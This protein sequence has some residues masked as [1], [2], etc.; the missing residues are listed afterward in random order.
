MPPMVG[1]QR[2][3][4]QVPTF[5]VPL[6]YA[7]TSVDE[8][9]GMFSDYDIYFI[10]AQLH[11][12]EAMLARDEYGRPVA[13]TIGLSKPRQNG[14]SHGARMYSVWMACVEGKGILYSAHLGKT[15]NEF[16]K[17]LL[18]LFTDEIKYPDMCATVKE[19][20]RQS[21][22]EGIYFNNGGFIEFQTR[23][24]SGA[25]GSSYS[26][27]VVDEAQE[28]TDAQNNG[29]LPSASAMGA[30]PQIIMIGTPPDA[31]CSGTVFKRLHS[32]AHAHAEG[33][34]DYSAWW[35][36]FAASSLP[37]RDATKQELLELAY[38]YN[39]MLGYRMTEQAILNEID[40]LS[41]DGF[42][43]E[44]LG[45][46]SPDDGGYEHVV[47]AAEWERCATDTPPADGK[48]AYGVKYSPDNSHVAICAA[49]KDRNDNTMPIHVEL[50]EYGDITHGSG[51]V[52]DWLVEREEI[53]S[54][55]WADGAGNADNLKSTLRGRHVSALYCH[56]CSTK[57][58]INAASN[59]QQFIRARLVTHF[60]QASLTRSVVGSAKRPIGKTT[61]SPTGIRFVDSFGFGNGVDDK[62]VEIDS[63]IAEA[64]SLALM[65][66]NSSYRDPGEEV[67]VASW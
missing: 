41:V 36:E 59:M 28:L 58:I 14:K 20:V 61:K 56:T 34:S 8:C 37:K 5:E 38:E 65:A 2:L 32:G 25:R 50:V 62:G 1:S 18:E 33:N 48:V 7:Y 27:I 12:L 35:M 22:R 11:E 53:G 24:T 21:G 26:V 44:R 60:N 67:E 16:F 64:A 40:S 31:S 15:V 30:V 3:G 29:L 43:H 66:V 55:Y 46:W 4:N 39:P 51:W 23:T 49:I 54:C 10:P 57:D 42:A 13:V 17:I 52:A 45:W 6:E 9:V 19:I 63:I 47:S